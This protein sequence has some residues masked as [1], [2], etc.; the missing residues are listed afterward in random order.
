[1]DELL[2]EQHAEDDSPAHTAEPAA[3]QEQPTEH[4]QPEAPRE[5]EQSLPASTAFNIDET[6]LYSE[7]KHWVTVFEIHTIASD[8]KKEDVIE[9]ATM[10]HC[11]GPVTHLQYALL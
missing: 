9:I 6:D 8:L 2:H 5:M 3:N 11:L 7:W 4:K 10:L 1:V